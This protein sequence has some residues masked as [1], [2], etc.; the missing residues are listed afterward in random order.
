MTI[1]HPFFDCISGFTQ[2]YKQ[3]V[4]NI[5]KSKKYFILLA[6]NSNTALMLLT[7]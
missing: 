2:F 5:F 4:M 3:Y 7:D 6:F 1:G